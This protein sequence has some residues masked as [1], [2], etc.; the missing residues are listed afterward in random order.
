ML[1]IPVGLLF[2]PRR[3]L[4]LL[5][6]PMLFVLLYSNMP[7]KELRFV[8][9]VVP[10]LTAAAAVGCDRLLALVASHRTSSRLVRF[11]V[12]SFIVGCVG[13]SALLTLVS[14]HSSSW[15]YAGGEALLRGTAVS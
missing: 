15:N 6:A 12:L 9:Y 10:L 13:A 5:F 1:L 11:A 7:H 8:I 14:A 4:H 3:L 2:E